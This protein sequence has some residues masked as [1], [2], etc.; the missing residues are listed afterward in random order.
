MQVVPKVI[1][2]IPEFVQGGGGGISRQVTFAV[3]S[4]AVGNFAE[5][6]GFCVVPPARVHNV[7][8]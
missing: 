1:Q 8:C 6:P 5:P 2:Y 4:Y 7:Y 3:V